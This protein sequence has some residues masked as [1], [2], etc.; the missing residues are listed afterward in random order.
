MGIVGEFIKMANEMNRQNREAAFYGVLNE[1]HFRQPSEW[2]LRDK[3]KRIC[4]YEELS[5]ASSMNSASLGRIDGFRFFL[6][7]DYGWS[8][9]DVNSL[10]D[11]EHCMDAKFYN[12]AMDARD[13]DLYLDNLLL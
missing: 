1:Y 5:G 6:I 11:G 2:D 12:M 10:T 3:I 9:D 13:D 4:E 8:R 7:K